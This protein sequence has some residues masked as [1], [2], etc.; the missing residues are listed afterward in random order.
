MSANILE[1]R[2]G[3]PFRVG[4]AVVAKAEQQ[5]KP[6]YNTPLNF[7]QCLICTYNAGKERLWKHM[8]SC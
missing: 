6:P 8:S 4:I 7:S 5:L 2:D 3:S 1:G